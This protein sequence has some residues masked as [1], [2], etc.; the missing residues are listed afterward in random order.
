M[1]SLR[2]PVGKPASVRANSD[3]ALL[4]C[5]QYGNGEPTVS[6]QGLNGRQVLHYTAP[7]QYSD[8]GPHRAKEGK[9]TRHPAA[10][11]RDLQHISSEGDA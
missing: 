4:V 2:N 11:M 3:R 9:T 7:A 5:P 1:L 8:F 10:M 6:F